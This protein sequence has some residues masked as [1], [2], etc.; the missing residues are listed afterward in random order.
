MNKNFDLLLKNYANLIVKKGLNIQKDGLLIINSPIKCDYFARKVAE[1][2]FKIGAK[3]VFINYSDEDFSKIR[4]QNASLE[5]VS[6]IP[7]FEVEKYNYYISRG[8]SVFAISASNPE[9]LKDVDPKK[10][11]SSVQARSKALKEV[12]SDKLMSNEN[13]WCIVSI[14]TKEWAMKVFN[15]VS[16][17]EA[18]ELLWNSIFDIMR[19]NSEDPI[20]SWDIHLNNIKKHLEFFNKNNFKYLKMKNSLGTDL[21]V[22]LPL[23]HIWCGGSEFTKGGVEF[24]ANMPT[25]EIFTTPK[26]DGVN[27]I[28][29]ASKPLNY[30]GTLI[31]DFNITFKD[32]E[33]VNFDAKEGLEALRELINTDEGSKYLGE[34]ALV[35]Y[36]SPISNSNIL[37]YN[38]LYDENASCHLAIGEAYPSCIKDGENL[39]KEELLK[40]GSNV[41]LTHVDFMFGTSDLEI[42]GVTY[43][44]TTI[45]IFKDG[46]YAF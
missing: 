36:N 14:P 37:F 38:T 8:A 45:E 34:V 40:I 24:I 20:K 12:Y 22:E 1:A 4:L 5:T 43:D 41:S 21:K 17:K 23:N 16:S 15:D 27:G 32:G 3:D 13:A 29:Y 39:S 10:I 2:A 33:I 6:E 30:N 11:S 19:L 25:E 9:L 35:P 26:R 7:D 31:N 18:V 28:V 44:D 46:N 42:I